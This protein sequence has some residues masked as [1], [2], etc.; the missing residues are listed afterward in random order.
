MDSFQP[1]EPLT[2]IAILSQNAMGYK[3][4]A[5]SGFP[6]FTCFTPCHFI[7]CFSRICFHLRNS[8]LA[9]VSTHNSC[10]I[11]PSRFTLPESSLFGRSGKVRASPL[12]PPLRTVHETFALTRLKPYFK[13]DL[14]WI[15]CVPV[16]DTHGVRA[17]GCLCRLAHL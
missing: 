11:A 10:L 6:D 7:G 8:P 12:S 1:P 2:H 3:S 16:C 5:W 4:L 17:E 9:P 15:Y 14:T 13:R